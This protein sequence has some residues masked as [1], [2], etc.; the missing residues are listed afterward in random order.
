M[1]LLWRNTL[2]SF[3]LLLTCS[4]SL[5]LSENKTAAIKVA[6]LYYFSKFVTWPESSEF[7]NEQLNL[8]TGG[9]SSAVEFQ[10]STINGKRVGEKHL[11]VVYLDI[12]KSQGSASL[13]EELSSSLS[14]CKILYVSPGIQTWYLSHYLE[15]PSQILVVSD[16]E[17]TPGRVILLHTLNNKLSFEINTE[18]ADAK[19]L[20][21]S[22]KLLR[23]S[24]RRAQ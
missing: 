4:S 16:S 8:C 5:A 14:D 20:K 9:V 3:V 24:K 1:M 22:S 2:I 15:L 21:I 11:N 19:S 12:L 7:P 23:L 13:S 18:I 10:L 17:D 6:Y